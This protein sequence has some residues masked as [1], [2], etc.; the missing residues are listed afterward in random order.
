MT[1]GDI[2]KTLLISFVLVVLQVLVLN[3][4]SMFG[5]ATPLL[6]IYPVL[7]TKHNTPRWLQLCGAFL[8]GL[9]CD[10]FSNT[11][12]VGAASMTFVAFV[13]PNI[14]NLFSTRE[15][16]D[17][18]APSAK[19]LGWNKFFFYTLTMVLLY[20]LLYFT[21][22]FFTFYHWE[23]WLACILGSTLLTSLFIIAIE[24]LQKK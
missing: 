19:N 10:I 6:Y 8:Q 11:P 16:E 4:I 1:N 22:E 13:Q 24:N 14:A 5:V 20:C 17:S 7:K 23:H 9:I 12:G 15:E 3:N 18:I 2:I 21:L